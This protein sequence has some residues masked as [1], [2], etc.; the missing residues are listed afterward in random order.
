VQALAGWRAGK[1][2]QRVLLALVILLAAGLA[3]AFQGPNTKS[4]K[5]PMQSRMDPGS[6]H[7]GRWRSGHEM[8]RRYG[9]T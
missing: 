1:N 2:F 6:Q 9:P 7:S 5:Q 4:R 3:G 8:V